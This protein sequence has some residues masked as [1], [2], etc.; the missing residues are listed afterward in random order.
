MVRLQ[1]SK[2]AFRNGIIAHSE[3][4]SPGQFCIPKRYHPRIPKRNQYLDIYSTRGEIGR[5]GPVPWEP[6]AP[7]VSLGAVRRLARG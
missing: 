5:A 2:R 4:V 1:N 3:T 6:A 7:V